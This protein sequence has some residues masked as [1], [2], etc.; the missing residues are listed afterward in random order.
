[1]RTIVLVCIPV[2]EDLVRTLDHE[3]IFPNVPSEPVDVPLHLTLSV[4]K[5]DLD[6]ETLR[7]I[8]TDVL[9]PCKFHEFELRF[10]STEAF[11]KNALVITTDLPKELARLQSKLSE[12]LTKELE[13]FEE[14]KHEEFRPHV[15]VARTVEAD[16]STDPLNLHEE[17]PDAVWNVSSF[18]LWIK[19]D[20]GEYVSVAAYE[21]A[22]SKKKPAKPHFAIGFFKAVVRTLA[23]VALVFAAFLPL[24][25][26]IGSMVE[27]VMKNGISA[28]GVLNTAALVS[29]FASTCALSASLRKSTRDRFALSFVA[30][31]LAM[32]VFLFAA[33][34]YELWSCQNSEADDFA[35]YWIFDALVWAGTM[36]FALLALH[37]SLVKPKNIP[38][39]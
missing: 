30:F 38:K 2:P 21:A 3:R 16:E 26:L 4:G 8:A 13:G 5:I 36:M 18:E 25:T 24:I 7:E 34:V 32:S 15:T 33:D 31:A 14:F 22:K 12:V 39:T 11:S 20:G 17:L 27:A 28:P 35:C 9:K 10:T 1:M 6:T 29:T 19:E 23:Q 37:F